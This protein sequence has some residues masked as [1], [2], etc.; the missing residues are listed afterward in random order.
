MCFFRFDR[1][2]FDDIFSM[3]H[4]TYFYSRNEFSIL[5]RFMGLECHRYFSSR[6]SVII[7]YLKMLYR[8]LLDTGENRMH[9]CI[10]SIQNDFR[11]QSQCYVSWGYGNVV[12][13]ETLKISKW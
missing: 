12:D 7:F 5:R 11:I 10:S 8:V 4:N 1:N 9:N 3:C 6:R 2:I 13:E